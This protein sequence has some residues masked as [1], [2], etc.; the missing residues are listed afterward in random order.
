M[1]SGVGITLL[2]SILPMPILSDLIVSNI[3]LTLSSSPCSFKI[4]VT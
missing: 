1:L 4:F 3:A 2:K